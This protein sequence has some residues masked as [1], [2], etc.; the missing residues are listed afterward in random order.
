MNASWVQVLPLTGGTIN[1]SVTIKSTSTQLVLDRPV[2]STASDI[3]FERNGVARWLLRGGDATAETGGNVGSNLELICFSDSGVTI[4]T[5]IAVTRSS[6]LVSLSSLA[7]SGV[8]TIS[9]AASINTIST[10]SI[11]ASAGTIVSCLFDTTGIH[12]NQWGSFA[13]GISF[14]W[15]Q[16]LAGFA[17]VVVDNVLAYPLANASDERL[18]QDIVASTCDCLAL[19]KTL[20]LYQYSWMNHSDPSNPQPDPNAPTIPVGFIAQRLQTEAP[21]CVNPG[22]DGS[23]SVMQVWDIDR[24]TMLAYLVGAVQ[25]LA[26]KIGALEVALARRS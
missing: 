1:G 10:N 26:T 7:V 22:D 20:S 23:G 24:N 16:D 13:N 8:A 18:K 14:R 15:Q 4:G 11:T 2:G 5:P 3:F 25:Q 19:V 17:S 21:F 6:A 12:Y 9:G